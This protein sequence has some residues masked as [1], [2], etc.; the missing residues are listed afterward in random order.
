MKSRVVVW[1]SLLLVVATTSPCFGQSKA[2]T[3]SMAL[4][5]IKELV[6]E[7]HAKD[8]RLIV[9]FKHGETISGLVSPLSDNTFSLKHTHGVFG[10]GESV[11]INY[12]DVESLTGR[13]PFVKVL[14][15]IGTV[16]IITVGVAVILP[17][18]LI[19]CLLGHP[20]IPDC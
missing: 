7:A 16:S 14:K 15:G 11:T 12:A 3:D 8:K 2:K 17:L 10:E 9:R 13:N 20:L 18:Q 4:E 1:L 5:Q 19:S 6:A